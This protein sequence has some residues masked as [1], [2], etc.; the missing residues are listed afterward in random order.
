MK[1]TRKIIEIDEDLCDGCGN[2]IISCAEGALELIDGK[3]KLVS[4]VYCDGLGACLGECPTGALQIVEREADDFDEAAVEAHLETRHHAEKS[5]PDVLPCGCPSTRLQTFAQSDPCGCANVPAS[6]ESAQSR[7]THWPVQL[8]LVPATAPFLKNADLLIAADCT[9]F[10]YASFHQDFLNGRTLLVGCPKFDD[11]RA[12]VEKLSEIFS[13]ADVQSI[14]VVV[15]E[16]PCCHGLPM[17]VREAMRIA[18]KTIPFELVVL[19]VRGEVLQREAM[20][21]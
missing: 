21:A 2:C 14:T 4:E 19:S 13:K 12:Y 17:I 5:T 1:V 20:V 16:V 9:S 18:G 3:A 8:N 11:A 7:L 10:A 15:M 6:Y